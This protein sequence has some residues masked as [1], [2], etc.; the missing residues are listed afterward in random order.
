MGG[1]IVTIKLKKYLKAFITHL[2][3]DEG[4]LIYGAEPVWFSRKDSIGRLINDWRRKPREGAAAIPEPLPPDSEYDYL[5]IEMDAN[6]RVKDDCLRTYLSADA[7]S[8][9]GSAIY[10]RFCAEAFA[11]VHDHL[12]RQRHSYPRRQP[13]KVKA[14]NDFIIELELSIDDGTIRRAFER[15]QSKQAKRVMKKNYAPA[16]YFAV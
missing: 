14:Y 3:D 15:E 12:N 8:M 16:N 5:T 13:V 1:I 10:D 6:E 9:V 7:Q 11:Y 2:R 4:R